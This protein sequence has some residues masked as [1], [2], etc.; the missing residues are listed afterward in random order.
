[1]NRQSNQ[2]YG[3]VLNSGFVEPT[4]FSQAA[5]VRAALR[6][7]RVIVRQAYGSSGTEFSP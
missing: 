5:D 6:V 4:L 1:M 7:S 2:R 3:V